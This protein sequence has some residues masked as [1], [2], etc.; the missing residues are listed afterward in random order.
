[1]K[2]L[3]KNKKSTVTLSLACS[4]ARVHHSASI[5]RLSTRTNLSLAMLFGSWS[6]SSSGTMRALLEVGFVDYY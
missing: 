6:S 1:M 3:N 4:V 2:I 5:Y